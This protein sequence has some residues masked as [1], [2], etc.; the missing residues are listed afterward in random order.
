MGDT[1]TN[2]FWQTVGKF[3]MAVGYISLGVI[4]KLA[5]DSREVKLTTG[6]IVFK[7]CIMLPMGFCSFMACFATNRVMWAGVVTP[8]TT[9]LGEPIALWILKNV[10]SWL[11]WFD[12]KLKNKN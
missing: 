7:I 5:I 8:I 6:Q 2:D 9:M 4:A 10:N 11:D 1:K 3:A 12:N